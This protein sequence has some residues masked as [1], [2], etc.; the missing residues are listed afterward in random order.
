MLRDLLVILSIFLAAATTACASP[1][2]TETIEVGGVKYPHYPLSTEEVRFRFQVRP[3]YP[4]KALKE[5]RGG[6]TNVGAV[7]D[8]NGKVIGV[9]VESSDADRDIQKAALTAVKQWRFFPLETE[10]GPIAFVTFVPV[11]L[12]PDESDE[13]TK[14]A[15][16]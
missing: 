5:G 1:S 2:P 7:V 10:G 3:V 13:K 4:A 15:K 11:V 14:P 16:P 8:K 6:R 9:F 12:T